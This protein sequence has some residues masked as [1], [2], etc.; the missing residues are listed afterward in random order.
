[1][2]GFHQSKFYFNLTNNEFNIN[3][4]DHYIQYNVT[5]ELEQEC[6][7][8]FIRVINVLESKDINSKNDWLI[9]KSNFNKN[10]KIA[11]YCTTLCGQ[12]EN[13]PQFKAWQLSIA[14]NSEI[15]Y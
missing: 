9:Y 15:V 4:K 7:D 8:Y 6:I 12:R 5:P 3:I 1:M 2:H 14:L 10:K 11:H 13:C